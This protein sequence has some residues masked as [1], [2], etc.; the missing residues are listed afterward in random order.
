MYF[1]ICGFEL[2]TLSK[3][4]PYGERN[5][6]NTSDGK[7]AKRKSGRGRVKERKRERDG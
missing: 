4:N 5:C 6:E 3:S 1:S 7:R 2:F